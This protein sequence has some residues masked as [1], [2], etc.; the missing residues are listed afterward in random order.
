[1]HPVGFFQMASIGP[2]FGQLGYFNKFD[3]KELADKRPLERYVG[4][5]RRLLA[6]L[7]DRLKD[8]DWIMGDD[9]GIAD[10]TMLGWV[11]YLITF[12]EARELVDY[13]RL[14]HVPAWL[15]RGLA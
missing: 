9:Y 4:E 1:M 2:M 15:D 14:L 11:A 8:R 7:D 13:D 6:V 3:G 5:S 12:Y 10:I